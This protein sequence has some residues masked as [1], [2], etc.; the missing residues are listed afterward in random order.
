[1]L[2]DYVPLAVTDCTNHF[3]LLENSVYG[4]I[5]RIP[6]EIDE[7]NFNA[8]AFYDLRT[9]RLYYGEYHPKKN[10]KHK[11]ERTEQKRVSQDQFH[12]WV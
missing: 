10:D 6:L 7:L 2:F 5:E 9:L 8:A 1:M 11:Y 4:A 12:D 3:N